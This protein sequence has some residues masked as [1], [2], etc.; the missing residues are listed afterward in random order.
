MLDV[1]GVHIEDLGADRVRLTGSRGHAR[2]PTLKATVCYDGGWLGEGEISYAGPN[3]EAR[4]R[5][6]IEIL[7]ARLARIGGLR[8]HYDLIGVSSLFNDSEGVRLAALANRDARDVRVRLAVSGS[9]QRD[10][11][12]ALHEVEALYTAGPAGGGGVRL[13]I[14]PMLASASA[15]VPRERIAARVSM[16]G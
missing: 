3:A 14:V 10:V 8:K 15:F 13:N 4:G 6:A 16:I 9:R 7:E 1:S 12:L 5:L 2:P 11:Q